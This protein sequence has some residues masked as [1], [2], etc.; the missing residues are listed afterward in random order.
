MYTCLETFYLS[1]PL[2][3][4]F[5]VT[6]D[7][8]V[9]LIPLISQLS[10]RPAHVS[11]N[12]GTSGVSASASPNQQ[13]HEWLIPLL[14]VNWTIVTAYSMAFLP[15]RPKGSRRYYIQQRSAWSSAPSPASMLPLNLSPSI[16]YHTLTASA[17]NHVSSNSAA[18]I[19]SISLAPKYLSSYIKPI[20]VLPSRASLRS[21]TSG[22]LLIPRVRKK[23]SGTA[24]SVSQSQLHGT[25]FPKTYMIAQ[26]LF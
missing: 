17:S 5:G 12:L 26:S 20:S 21:S 15:Y 8:S 4:R 25:P 2:F 24:A 13:L 18:Y 19:P 14:H 9:T 7:T 10:S 6:L 1:P 22:Q 11:F 23:N 16:G 3:E